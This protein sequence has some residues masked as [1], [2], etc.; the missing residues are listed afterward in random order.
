MCSCCS[1]V[2]D[3]C[4]ALFGVYICVISA[5]HCCHL[6]L[7]VS[8]FVLFDVLVVLGACSV[9]RFVYVAQSCYSL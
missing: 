6:L 1:C 2:R 4:P 5:L 9:V 7:S 8:R 3:S